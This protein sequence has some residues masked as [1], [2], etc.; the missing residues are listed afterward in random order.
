MEYIK[1]VMSDNL[2][3]KKNGIDGKSEYLLMQY[4]GIIMPPIL[5]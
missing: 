5:S 3:G 2:S 4:P 1:N